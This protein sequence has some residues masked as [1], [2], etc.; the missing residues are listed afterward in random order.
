MATKDK[1]RLL[2]KL[3]FL[4]KFVFDVMN[5]PKVRIDKNKPQQAL[6][7]YQLA[8]L[9]T[10][11]GAVIKLIGQDYGVD[12]A[13]L[14]R[15][16]L[17]NLINMI[18]I[19]KRAS[20]NRTKRFIQY[21]MLIR[22]KYLDRVRKHYGEHRAFAKVLSEEKQ[23]L[24]DY[25]K[26]KNKFPD[27]RKD[28]SGISISERAH[29]INFD[30]DYEVAYFLL[31]SIEHSDIYSSKEFIES[32]DPT[33]MV[34]KFKGGPSDAWVKESAIIGTK[35]MGQGIELFIKVFKLDKKYLKKLNRFG[36][37]FADLLRKP[38]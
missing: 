6:Y 23:I 8:K 19:E 32:I 36:K 30:Y 7:C 17:N 37:R 20:K 4:D 10:T 31:S 22:K 27:K 34:I 11:Y 13:I 1:E 9:H 35:Y 3:T 15:S 5:D 38:A 28:W 14:T 26:I 25:R 24:A 2:R 33:Q 16:M 12:A 21:H 29:E 18:W